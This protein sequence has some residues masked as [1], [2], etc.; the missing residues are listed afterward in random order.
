MATVPSVVPISPSTKWRSLRA[1]S[2]RAS[3][4]VPIGKKR[5]GFIP[6]KD[7]D[8]AGSPC[9]GQ[10]VG[11]GIEVGCCGDNDI[12]LSSAQMR[13][14]PFQMTA[15]ATK[16]SVGQQKEMRCFPCWIAPTPVAEILT[17]VNHQQLEGMLIEQGIEQTDQVRTW[18]RSVPDD[19]QRRGRGDRGHF[20]LGDNV[21]AGEGKRRKGGCP[22]A[23]SGKGPKAG[24]IGEWVCKQ[25]A[26][27]PPIL[28]QK[29]IWPKEPGAIIQGSPMPCKSKATKSDA[30][31][32][33][34]GCTLCGR[35]GWVICQI[36]RLTKNMI[37][38]MA[39]APKSPTDSRSPR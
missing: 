5:R 6:E 28:S 16:S 13:I 11:K 26:V 15:K 36:P 1:R 25:A 20:H 2:W 23:C 18:R 34:A 12:G 30:A 24:A 7:R 10:Q 4:E 29:R 35:G 19:S 37:N 17:Q 22:A 31:F 8:L 27:M 3:R 21:F 38:P 33:K 9:A 39:S 32:M 14:D